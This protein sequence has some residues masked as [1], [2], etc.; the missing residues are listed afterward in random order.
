MS[1][2]LTNTLVSSYSCSSGGDK[3]MESVSLN[4]TKFEY[5]YITRDA[6]GSPTPK[7]ASYDLATAKKG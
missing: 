4:F 6:K 3:P 1:Y 7:T 5:K 2:E